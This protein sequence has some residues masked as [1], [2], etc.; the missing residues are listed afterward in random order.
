[1]A[2]VGAPA[3]QFCHASIEEGMNH[4]WT[5]MDTNGHEEAGRLFNHEN[6]EN[7]ERDTE[8]GVSVEQNA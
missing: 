7:H 1:M 6:H 5:P 3:R 4:E 2:R 8:V